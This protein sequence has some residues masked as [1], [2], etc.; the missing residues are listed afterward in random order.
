MFTFALRLFPYLF[1]LVRN[2][3]NILGGV[4]EE[5]ELAFVDELALQGHGEFHRV[6][7]TDADMHTEWKEVKFPPAIRRIVSRV[8]N[9]V[10]VGSPLCKILILIIPVD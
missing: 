5:I 3:P 6:L 2:L 4:Y 7:Y 9:R 1:Q 10:F 8:S